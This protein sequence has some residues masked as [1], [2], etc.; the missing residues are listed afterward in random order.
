MKRILMLIVAIAG[1]AM[2]S[3][4][5]QKGEEEAILKLAKSELEAFLRR[6]SLNW[7]TFYIQNE[8]TNLANA[9]KGYFFPLVG[10]KRINPEVI[11]MFRINKPSR[12]DNIAISKPI[13][14]ISDQVATVVY[15]QLVTASEVDTLPP[16]SSLEYRT[17][18]KEGGK[19]KI[20]SRV[21]FD[22]ASYNSAKPQDIEDQF[23]AIGYVLLNAKKL[24]QALKVFKFNVEMYPLA[25]NPYDS[26][27]EAYATAGNK[28]LA[29]ENYEKSIKLN[30]QNDNGIKM[31]KKLKGE[32]SSSVSTVKD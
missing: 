2:P 32:Q 30:P 12:Y 4:F 10:W 13:F 25:W 20:T 16:W 5:A 9:G 8:K 1:L 26:L 22:T 31:L 23:N 24:D 19:W 11:T 14:N 3:A 7:K 6:D 15:D 21:S 18:V 28:K 17:F 27:A 29:I